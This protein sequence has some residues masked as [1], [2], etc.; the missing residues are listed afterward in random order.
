[1]NIISISNDVKDSIVRSIQDAVGDDILEDIRKNDLFTTNSVPS[2]IWDFIN[3]NI[4]SNSDCMLCTVAKAVRKPWQMV[5]VFD[6]K[7]QNIITFMR[8]RRFLEICKNQRNRRSMHYVDLLTRNFNREL[9]APCEQLCLTPHRFLDECYL[10][11]NVNT[12][13]ADLKNEVDLVRHHV[14]ILFETVEYELVSV[15]AVM[16]SSSLDIVCEEDWTHMI[17]KRQ[18]V[19]TDT[20]TEPEQ[21]SNNPTMNLQLKPKALNRKKGK[22]IVKTDVNVIKR[23]G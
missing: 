7:S 17:N 11:E 20:I 13:L 1:M 23:E 14:M 3:R 22:P 6:K 19:I 16:L 18:S 15:R 4:R 21:V 9:I 12:M 5:V 10:V 2:R 8:E